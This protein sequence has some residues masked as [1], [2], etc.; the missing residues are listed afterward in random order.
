MTAAKEKLEGFRK[1][2]ITKNRVWGTFMAHWGFAAELSCDPSEAQ[3]WWL[4]AGWEG[5][6][7]AAAQIL[8]CRSGNLDPAPSLLREKQK[9][10]LKN[11]L[12]ISPFLG[13]ER[14]GGGDHEKG[15][16]ELEGSGDSQEQGWA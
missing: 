8:P 9:H 5:V 10:L 7:G 6:T 12:S 15:R 13:Q 16:A 4:R 2:K 1:A 14:A 11:R 3:G